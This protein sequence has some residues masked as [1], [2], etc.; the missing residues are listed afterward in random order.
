MA[1]T[2]ATQ[3]YGGRVAG[4]SSGGG[5][6]AAETCRGKSSS[7]HW[8]R[9]AVAKGSNDKHSTFQEGHGIASTVF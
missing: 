3:T 6:I 9:T 2:L 5:S 4:V 8:R 1:A 7:T